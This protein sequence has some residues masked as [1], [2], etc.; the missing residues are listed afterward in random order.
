ML[1]HA[2]VLTDCILYQ[3]GRIHPFYCERAA[4]G[5]LEL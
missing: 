3:E 4:L 2:L 5:E 1:K